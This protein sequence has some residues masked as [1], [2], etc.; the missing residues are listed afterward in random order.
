MF[1]DVMH[2]M[3]CLMKVW[4]LLNGMRVVTVGDCPCSDARSL[5]IGRP[6]EVQAAR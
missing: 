6:V 4:S 1:V 5:H 2:A 3:S